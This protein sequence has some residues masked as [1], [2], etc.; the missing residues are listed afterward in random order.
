MKRGWMSAA[1]LSEWE[2]VIINTTGRVTHLRLFKNNHYS[3]KYSIYSL[4]QNK[5]FKEYK[6]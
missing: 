5:P 6:Y 1:P 3:S 2:G 4:I